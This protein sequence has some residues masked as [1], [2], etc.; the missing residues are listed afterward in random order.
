MTSVMKPPSTPWGIVLAL[1]VS[2]GFT[3]AIASLIPLPFATFVSY[4]DKNDRDGVAHLFLPFEKPLSHQ[5]VMA[6][7][8]SRVDACFVDA[9]RPRDPRCL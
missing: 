1:S 2:C 9:L 3:L 4:L 7:E 8:G 5:G 6:P